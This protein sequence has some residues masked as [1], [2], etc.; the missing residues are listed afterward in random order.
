VEVLVEGK[1]KSQAGLYQGTTDNYLKVRFPA[2]RHLAAGSR[3]LVTIQRA[4]P[5][6]L[7]ATWVGLATDLS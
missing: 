6:G 7:T 1:I 5:N 4:S 3:V 2:P